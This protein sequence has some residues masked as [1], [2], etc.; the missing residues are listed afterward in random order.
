MTEPDDDSGREFTASERK[1]IRKGLEQDRR[2]RWF[3][4][5]IKVWAG[6]AAAV[7]AASYGM[8]QAFRDSGIGRK[9]GGP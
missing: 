5:S 2:V 8:Y 1:E 3:W 4:S 7:S 6:Y 9:F